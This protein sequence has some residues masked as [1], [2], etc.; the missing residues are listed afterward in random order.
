MFVESSSHAIHVPSFG[1]GLLAEWVGLEHNSQSAEGS[2]E[3]YYLSS[4]YGGWLMVIE[5]HCEQF[6][7]I[8]I[9]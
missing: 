4:S 5:E 7:E 2:C 3:N 9:E 6:F 1:I 8:T